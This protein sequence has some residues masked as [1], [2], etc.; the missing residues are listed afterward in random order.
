[1]KKV[2][3]TLQTIV[4]LSK[5]VRIWLGIVVTIVILLGVIPLL[6]CSECPEMVEV[7]AGSFLMGSPESEKGR[8]IREGPTHQVTIKQPFKVG[9]YEVTFAEWEA[10]VSGGGCD[11][12]SPNDSRWGR[13]RRPVINVSWKDAQNY[14][15]WL[16]EQTGEAYRLLSEAEWE[17]VARAGTTTPFH[18]GET[19][20]TDQANYNGNFSYMSGRKGE[21]REKTVPVG[22]FPAN[23]FGLH[24]VHGNVSEW[25]Q[26]C[27][28][29]DYK[30]APTDGSAWESGECGERVRH[31][32]A[33]NYDPKYLRSAYRTRNAP[34]DRDSKFGF[35]VAMTLTQ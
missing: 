4:N 18:F 30:D 8:E 3:S 31:G 33:W 13:G 24:D 32:S 35:R 5:E 14:V 27:W 28:H 19:I 7:P 22:S 17:Y 29:D 1:M 23:A 26:D 34:T 20:S 15:R 9:V 2:V 10:C 6:Y 25:T 12:Y 16:S 11:G 21:N